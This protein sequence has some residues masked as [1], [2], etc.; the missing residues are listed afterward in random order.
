MTLW[1]LI[2]SSL[3]MGL[4]LVGVA[5]IVATLGFAFLIAAGVGGTVLML[6]KKPV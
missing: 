5:H 4:L 1:K 6:T 2:L 3:A